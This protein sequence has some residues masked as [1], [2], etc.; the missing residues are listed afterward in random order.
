MDLADRDPETQ[1]NEGV[2]RGR[3]DCEEER[4]AT[5]G[6]GCGMVVDGMMVR[7]MAGF[8]VR[9]IGGVAHGPGTSNCGPSAPAVSFTCPEATAPS[10]MVLICCMEGN[11]TKSMATTSL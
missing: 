2:E 8:L 4:G 6:E 5:E 3:V 10:R 7:R 11:L 1:S 9:G